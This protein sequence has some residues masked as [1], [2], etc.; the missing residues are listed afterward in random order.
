MQ[1]DELRE[2]CGDLEGRTQA[3]QQR[4][5]ASETAVHSL[6]LQVNVLQRRMRTSA[7]QLA[8]QVLASAAFLSNPISEMHSQKS[9]LCAQHRAK[10]IAHVTYRG[11]QVLDRHCM[12]HEQKK[13]RSMA[14]S[15]EQGRLRTRLAE[16]QEQLQAQKQMGQEAE[17]QLQAERRRAAELEAQLAAQSSHADHAVPATLDSQTDVVHQLA[18]LQGSAAALARCKLPELYG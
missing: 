18:C 17:A 1:R 11:W 13:H 9:G 3:L 12:S 10:T 6:E 14:Q 15:E 7:V 8:E 16:A 5:T 4:C 2:R